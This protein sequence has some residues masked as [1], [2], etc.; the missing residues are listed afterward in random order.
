MSTKFNEHVEMDLMFYKSYV[1]CHFIDRASR[2]HAAVVVSDKEDVTLLEAMTCWVSHHG[3][4]SELIIDGEGGVTQSTWFQN[5]LKARGI[6]LNVRAP[7]QRARYIE[8]RG[9]LLRHGLHVIEEQMEHE[10]VSVTFPILHAEAVHAGNCLTRVGV[11][12][13]QPSCLWTPTFHYA[14][15]GYRRR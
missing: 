14:S 7:S 13:P 10:G 1:I 11:V 2:W 6:K 3:P 12:T 5:E 15:Y 9:A 4:M 8:R